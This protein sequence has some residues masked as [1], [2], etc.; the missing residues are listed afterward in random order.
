MPL[1]SYLGL[2]ASRFDALNKMMATYND[3]IVEDDN[4]SK[5]LTKALDAALKAIER[6]VTDALAREKR[7]ARH[8]GLWRLTVGDVR[9]ALDEKYPEHVKDYTMIVVHGWTPGRGLEGAGRRDDADADLG[10]RRSGG[11]ADD[12]LRAVVTRQPD[13]FYS[14]TDPDNG[15]AVVIDARKA[16]TA[17]KHRLDARLVD[18]RAEAR[19][20][21]ATHA[22][23]LLK[24][25][26]ESRHKLERVD[27]RRCSCETLAQLALHASLQEALPKWRETV[28][29]LLRL[30]WNLKTQDED[31]HDDELDLWLEASL[32]EG[33]VDACAQV[34]E[35]RKGRLDGEKAALR[36]E[37]DAELVK[38]RMASAAISESWRALKPERLG[39]GENA[40]ATTAQAQ[41]RLQQFTERVQR[42]LD[43]ARDFARALVALDGSAQDGRPASGSHRCGSAR[44]GRG[45]GGFVRS[46][47]VHR[48]SR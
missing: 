7:W 14:A 5:T 11:A 36:A 24:L 12:V 1:D 30:E 41:E 23:G 38:A 3:L 45:L 21:Y 6:R 27:E 2:R 46:N 28:Q 18:L 44:A 48:Y 25:A 42:A 26:K 17:V 34:L 35:T 9:R 32:V 16:H 39:E 8:S 19:E 22:S 47:S 29:G 13:S 31:P 10:S 33:A 4:S 43:D 37:A 40:C 20:R 15:L